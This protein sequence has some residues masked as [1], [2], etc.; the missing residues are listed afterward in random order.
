MGMGRQDH[1]DPGFHGFLQ[2]IEEASPFLFR[3]Y[4]SIAIPEI[5]HA[6]F[7]ISGA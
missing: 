5:F 2:G 6:L 7:S 3:I 4:V 1:I